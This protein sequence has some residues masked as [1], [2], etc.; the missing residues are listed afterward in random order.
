MVKHLT[1]HFH[2]CHIDDNTTKVQASFVVYADDTLFS[3]ALIKESRG[4][5]GTS[6]QVAGSVV[7]LTV[8][9]VDLV[10]LTEPLVIDFMVRQ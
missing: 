3:S 10:N 1:F 7:S 4:G 6:L 2:E 9:D 5:N 8:E